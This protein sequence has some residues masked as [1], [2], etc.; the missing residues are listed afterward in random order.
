MIMFL[1]LFA[2]LPDGKLKA[3]L[4]EA[5]QLRLGLVGG[6][7]DTVIRSNVMTQDWSLLLVS[8]VASGVVDTHSNRFVCSCMI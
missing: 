7:F 3:L 6:M 1:L 5:L 4:Q 8:L 2:G